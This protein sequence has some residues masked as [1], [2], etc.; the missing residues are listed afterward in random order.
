MSN[1]MSYIALSLHLPISVR[2]ALG[3]GA[4]SARSARR[5]RGLHRVLLAPPPVVDRGA[6]DGPARSEI[7]GPTVA[8][9]QNRSYVARRPQRAA[10]RHDVLA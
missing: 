3:L 4:P 6:I 10:R 1:I 2:A 5:R 8:G 9:W 7:D